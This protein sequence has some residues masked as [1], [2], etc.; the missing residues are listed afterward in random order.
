MTELYNRKDKEL[1]RRNLRNKSTDPEQ[2]LWGILRN[3]QMLN[4]KFRRQYS[5]GRYILDFYCPE[6][7]LAI[8]VDG[9]SHFT[10][11]G[12]ELDE[13]RTTYLDSV[14]ISVIRVNNNDVME[15]LEGVCDFLVGH[16]QALQNRE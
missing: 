5:V 10:D 16:I 9:G 8:E 13:I 12:K 6:I 2:E 1:L 14:H 7:R 15:N 3:R 11:L 4:C